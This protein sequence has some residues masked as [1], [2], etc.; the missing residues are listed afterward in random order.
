MKKFENTLLEYTNELLNSMRNPIDS[1]QLVSS[2]WGVNHLTY[3]AHFDSGL[4]DTTKEALLE[5]E[6]E[7]AMFLRKAQND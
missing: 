5:A 3:F 1:D 6:K 7:A 4:T 2:F